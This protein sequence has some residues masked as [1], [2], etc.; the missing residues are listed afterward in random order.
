MI[1]NAEAFLIQEKLTG[2][3]PAMIYDLMQ[4]VSSS[5]PGG[6]FKKTKNPGYD[7]EDTFTDSEIEYR[8]YY[9]TTVTINKVEYKVDISMGLSYYQANAY[10]H[11]MVYFNYRKVQFEGRG[12]IKFTDPYNN[13]INEYSLPYNSIDFD[14]EDNDDW[15]NDLK[16]YFAR[17]EKCLLQ[18]S[19]R[20][21]AK[22]DRAAER[23]LKKIEEKKVKLNAVKL[24]LITKHGLTT[25]AKVDEL[26][27][28][29]MKTGNYKERQVIKL[30]DNYV[31]LIK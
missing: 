15:L 5:R 1:S 22:R 13:S 21:Y 10:D 27:E 19:L 2:E 28:I 18:D 26:F 7:P 6:Y 11:Q 3:Y 31:S 4:V 16:K 17:Y 24:D 29:S 12:E 25:S 20:L 30:F 8:Y 9:K 14:H 23:L